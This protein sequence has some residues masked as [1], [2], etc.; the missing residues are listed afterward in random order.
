MPANIHELIRA[1]EGFR[2]QVYDDATGRPLK[3]GDVLKGHPTIGYGRALDVNGIDAREAEALLDADIARATTA[4]QEIVGMDTFGGL[5]SA[6]Q[7]ALV[8][9]AF[10]LGRAGL[11]KFNNMLSAIRRGHWEVAAEE[12]LSSLWGR[13]VPARSRAIATMLL[14][15]NWPAPPRDQEPRAGAAHGDAAADQHA[16]KG[17]K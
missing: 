4:A 10:Q 14:T 17:E 8:S 6:R 9:M 13:Q 12:A 5:A 2:A 3:P 16:N 11:G 7:A 1:H 15:G